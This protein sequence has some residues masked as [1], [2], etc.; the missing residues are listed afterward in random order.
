[1]KYVISILVQVYHYLNP[2]FN[3]H[4][5]LYRNM[6]FYFR[7]IYDKTC[8]VNPGKLLTPVTGK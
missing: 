2:N 8:I 7:D 1:M 5:I 4:P 6:R 3:N